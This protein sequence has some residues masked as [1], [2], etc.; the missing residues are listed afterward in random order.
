MEDLLETVAMNRSLAASFVLLAASVAQA[1][2]GEPPIFSAPLQP[3]TPSKRGVVFRGKM[4][5][6]LGQQCSRASATGYWTPV[7][8]SKNEIKRLEAALPRFMASHKSARWSGR[9]GDFHY[10]YGALIRGPK[11]LIYVNAL[12]DES[13]RYRGVTENGKPFVPDPRQVW[14]RGAEV[15]CDGGPDYW[16]VEFDVANGRFQNLDFNGPPEPDR[17]R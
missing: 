7:A 5:R 3:V 14:R 4:A 11:R 12:A 10:Q 6:E 9:F 15:V 8:P 13:I 1:Q 17:Y 2:P 16:G